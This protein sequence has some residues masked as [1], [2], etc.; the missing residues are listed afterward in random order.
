MLTK[1]CVGEEGR[2]CGGMGTIHEV[3]NFWARLFL[4]LAGSI[5]AFSSRYFGFKEM[6]WDSNCLDSWVTGTRAMGRREGCKECKW[7]NII[8]CFCL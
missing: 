6:V 3:M 2:G 5:H 4:A 1:K 8:F 7:I